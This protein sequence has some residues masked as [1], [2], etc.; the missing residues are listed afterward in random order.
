MDRL[1]QPLHPDRCFKVGTE[2]HLKTRNSI[3][4]LEN[5]FPG[6]RASG[7]VGAH[8]DCQTTMICALEMVPD[9]FH[10]HI[11]TSTGNEI[12]GQLPRLC[13]PANR[14]ETI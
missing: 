5:T 4:D 14:S 7:T 3:S 2:P 13:L 6:R 11:H 8:K 9:A 1:T 12:M 10:L